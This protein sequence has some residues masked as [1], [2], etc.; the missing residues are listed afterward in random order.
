MQSFPRELLVLRSKP[1]R[2]RELLIWERNL[3]SKRIFVGIPS[4]H[5]TKGK[6]MLIAGNQS[7]KVS[8]EVGKGTRQKNLLCQ[9]DHF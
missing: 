5:V 8:V 6:T 9:P 4:V 1:H 2:I 7:N 3:V